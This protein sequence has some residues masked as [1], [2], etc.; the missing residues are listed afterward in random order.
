MAESQASLPLAGLSWKG[1]EVEAS[2]RAVRDHVENEASALIRW[3]YTRKAPKAFMSWW[4]RLLA[5]IFTGLGG[6]VPI[7]AAFGLS[8][9]PIGS[10]YVLPFGQ[11]GYLFLALAA[12][13]V[14]FDKFFG[15]ST[16]WVRYVTTAMKLEK[17]REDFR[18]DWARLMAKLGGQTPTPEQIEQLI[19]RCREFSLAAKSQVELETQ[20]WVAEFQSNL[21]QLQ[22]EARTRLESARAGTIRLGVTN[23]SEMDDGYSV[24][25]NDQPVLERI[26]GPE[27]EVAAVQPGTH[28]VTASGTIAGV[29]ARATKTVTVQAGSTVE[30]TLTLAKARSAPDVPSRQ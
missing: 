9:I 20:A 13:C 10:S 29:P 24:L 6:L 4:L 21:S 17:M 18:L 26:F 5:I 14:L 8:N 23:A 28:T 19:Q 3:Y 25:V 30:T 16:G 2:L 12:A 1:E 11:L 22:Q 7:I 27:C 15:F